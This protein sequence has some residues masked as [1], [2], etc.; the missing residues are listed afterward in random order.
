MKNSFIKGADVKK[1]A[2][3]QAT[4]DNVIYARDQ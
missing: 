4:N 2:Y 3:E 1:K